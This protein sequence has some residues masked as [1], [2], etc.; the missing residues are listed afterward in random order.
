MPALVAAAL[1]FAISKYADNQM[2]KAAALGALGTVVLNQ[3]PYVKA[4]V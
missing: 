1:C 3:L 4:A 2:V